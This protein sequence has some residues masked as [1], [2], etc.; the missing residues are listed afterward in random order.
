MP[1]KKKNKD[2]ELGKL[3]YDIEKFHQEEN[4]GLP[5]VVIIVPIIILIV[6]LIVLV[7]KM[8]P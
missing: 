5:I 3:I 2:E 7:P 8:F 6:A 1:K 4:V